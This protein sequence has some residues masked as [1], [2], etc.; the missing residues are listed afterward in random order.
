MA[1]LMPAHRRANQ[2]G[3]GV[4]FH[5]LAA[6][7]PLIEGAEFEA[8]VADIRV[9]GLR[10][11]IWLHPNGSI[12]DGRNRYRA[13][14]EAKV[15]PRFRTWPCD[16]SPVKFILSLN[17]RRRHLNESQKGR[18]S[19]KVEEWLAKEAQERQLETRAKPGEK[20]GKVSATWR[21]PL[22]KGKASQQAAHLIGIGARTVERAK[23]LEAAAK[24]NPKASELAAEV[25]AGK[26]TL[27]H[28]LRILRKEAVTEA[29]KLPSDKFRVI[30]ADPPWKYNDKLM[31]DAYGST[32]YHYPTMTL[33]ELCALPIADLA[34]DNAVLFLWVTSPLLIEAA[35]PVI[36]AWGF[37]YKASFMW[38]KVKH[39][40]GNYNSV[41][42]EFLLVATRGSCT[43]DV[44]KLYDSVVSIERTEHSRKPPEFRQMI[45][46][47]YP[48]GKRLE[49]FA[50]E[51]VKGWT[52]WGA[53]TGKFEKAG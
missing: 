51:T 15:K 50:R 24:Q 11:A 38:D 26:T 53:E 42:H 36:K 3:V 25:D 44:P 37:T 49:L 45:E 1:V 41:R 19:L 40:V 18:L 39:N 6:I 7:F 22:D 17:L 10:E 16:E 23:Q 31:L 32:E 29:A 46:A 14:V 27:T 4:K 12:L 33:A 9:N 21:S 2:R 20:V 52:A 28:A 30:Y 34:E 35:P 48:Y 13:C 43:P 5:P 8:L 47:L